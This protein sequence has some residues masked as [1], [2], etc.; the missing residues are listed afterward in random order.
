A[1]LLAL[2]AGLAQS[3]AMPDDNDSLMRLVQIRDWLDGQGWFDLQQY[4]MG[5][6]GGFLMHWSRLVDLPVGLLMLAGGESFALLAWPTLLF[7]VAVLLIIR[8][9]RRLAG[10][11][12]TLP[13]LV[14]GAVS[15]HS[16]GLFVPG[17]L[18]HHNLQLVPLL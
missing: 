17:M 5:P 11:A 10:E 4:R 14:I 18:D 1:A 9:S 12:A 15:L 7:A 8:T 16:I 2:A 3:G 6:G 13:A